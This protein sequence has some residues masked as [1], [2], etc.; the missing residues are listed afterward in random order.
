MKKGR[1][2]EN[3]GGKKERQTRKKEDQRGRK[4]KGKMEGLHSLSEDKYA[5]S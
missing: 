3:Q 5:F 4:R 1:E 2:E